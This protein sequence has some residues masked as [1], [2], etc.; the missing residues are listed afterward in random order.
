MNIY[1]LPH[2]A[3]DPEWSARVANKK[4]TE[5]E[6]REWQKKYPHSGEQGLLSGIYYKDGWVYNLTDELKRYW[7]RMPFESTIREYYVEDVDALE[8]ALDDYFGRNDDDDEF[9]GDVEIREV[10]RLGT[11]E[12]PYRTTYE[13]LS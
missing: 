3:R 10:P 6:F 5:A 12:Y 13:K 9:I 4:M 11:D 1:M 7:V 8:T 2:V